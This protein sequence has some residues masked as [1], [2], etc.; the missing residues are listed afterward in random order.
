MGGVRDGARGA[1]AINWA[2]TVRPAFPHHSGHKSSAAG[3]GG[4]RPYRGVRNSNR[5]RG[6]GPLTH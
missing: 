5:C 2:K 1:W 3:I 4:T 6:I